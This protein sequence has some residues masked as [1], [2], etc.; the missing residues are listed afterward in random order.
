MS[1][2][3]Q[4][5]NYKYILDIQGFGWSSRLK[6]IIHLDMLIFRVSN[7]IS[8]FT[9]EF[10]QE[11]KH[12][13]PVHKNLSNFKQKILWAKENDLHAQEIARDSSNFA[14]K[15]LSEEAELCYW[16]YLLHEYAALQNFVPT[17]PHKNARPAINYDNIGYYTK[18]HSDKN[19]QSAALYKRK[20]LKHHTLEQP[21]TILEAAFFFLIFIL[22]LLTYT[23]FLWYCHSCIRVMVCLLVKLRGAFSCSVLGCTSY[24]SQCVSNVCRRNTIQHKNKK[25]LVD[26]DKSHR[27]LTRDLAV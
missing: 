16:Y 18:W 2:S 17:E 19:A 26:K 1:Y 12:F 11:G 15:Y 27:K 4:Q 20:N 10:L 7:D 8:D 23:C 5:N 9:I 13:V 24:S 21:L 22:S 3:R 14:S 25:V 6:E